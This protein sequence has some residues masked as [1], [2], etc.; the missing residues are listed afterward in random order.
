MT[1]EATLIHPD[2]GGFNP[3]VIN[4]MWTT[5]IRYLC[6]IR[7]GK[8]SGNTVT[9]SERY[10]IVA[11][12][13]ASIRL[14]INPFMKSSRAVSPQANASAKPPPKRSR[15]SKTSCRRFDIGTTLESNTATTATTTVRLV[16]L[17]GKTA[18]G[19]FG[20]RNSTLN[21]AKPTETRPAPPNIDEAPPEDPNAFDAAQWHDM[22]EDNVIQVVKQKRK[23]R[24]DSVSSLY[25]ITSR[26]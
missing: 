9:E 5:L 20:A 8:T 7:C 6:T 24:N 23:Q 19:R 22:L 12:E 11:Q 21:V 13:L 18:R 16:T 26:N 3:F 10:P 25:A 17:G 1:C 15:K 2:I 4:R 14:Q